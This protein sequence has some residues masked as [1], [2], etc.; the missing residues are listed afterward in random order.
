[1]ST[2][3]PF[4]EWPAGEPVGLLILAE[5]ASSRL[6]EPNLMSPVMN[7]SRSWWSASATNMA[8][9]P[10][11]EPPF[12]NLH[13]V[14]LV[15]PG[16]AS[17]LVDELRVTEPASTTV[18]AAAPV[19]PKSARRLKRFQSFMRRL[20]NPSR[21]GGSLPPA[22]DG[23][24]IPNDA[25]LRTLQTMKYDGRVLV[26]SLNRYRDRA[27]DPMTGEEKNGRDV[28]QPYFRRTLSTFSRLGARIV[29]MGRAR[30]V[31]TGSLDMPAWDDIMAVSYPTSDA[32]RR[33]IENPG[34]QSKARYRIAGLE[35]SWI[36]MGP[37][38]A[39]NAD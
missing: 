31:V 36:V 28:F 14:E 1:M 21:S 2:T 3:N 24:L 9:G 23:S 30:G 34:L 29:W 11:V 35:A 6:S 16:V 19:S 22:Y 7:A 12:R 32:V 33:M 38:V 17:S 26:L 18:L 10:S 5:G 4:A 25:Q 13:F 39:S 27:V 37:L 15:D 8:V 20:P